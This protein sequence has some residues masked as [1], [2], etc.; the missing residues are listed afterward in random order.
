MRL[1]KNHPRIKTIRT[2]AATALLALLPAVAGAQKTFIPETVPTE[3]PD[4][5]V[6]RRSFK[7]ADGFEVNLW[8][9]D[10]MIAKPIQI[11]WDAQGRMWVASSAMY[12]QI[13]PGE[14]PSDQV[15]VLEDTDDDGKADKST[16]FAD[17]LLI[18]TGVEPGD[19]G[20]YVANSTELIHLKD[21]DGDLKADERRIMLTGF[22]TEDTHHIIHT[23]RWGLDGRMY[24][25]Q[26]IYIHSHVETPHG[27]KRLMGSGIW[28][29]RP[30]TVEFDVFGRGMVNPWGHAFDRWGQSF[31]T[32]GAGGDGIYYAFPGAA[33]QTAK[34]WTGTQDMERVLTGMN[35][36]SPKYCGLEIVSGRHL[37]DDWQY[38]A[39]TNDFRANRV[40]RYQ[41]VDENGTFVSKQMPD[42]ITS[43]DVAFRPIDVKMG[44]DGAIYIADWYNPIINHGEVDFRDPRRDKAHGR[45]WRVSA[46]GRATL[47]KPK[48]V[49]APVADVLEQLKSPEGWT[50]HQ[51][52]LVLRSLGAKEVV[53]ALGAWLKKLDRKDANY[54]H[55][56]VEAL[57]AYQTLDTPEPELLNALL[58]SKTPQAR[59][60]ATR[61][62]PDWA[63][64]LPNPLELLAVQAV[65]ENTRVRIEA[66]RSL[67]RIPL[68]QAF[69]I[70]MTALDNRPEGPIDPHLEYALWTT[71]NEMKSVWMPAFQSGR[72]R[73]NE[74]PEHLAYALQA[75]KSPEALGAL[76]RQLRAGQIPPAARADVFELIASVG[77]PGEAGAV[78]EIATA[79]NADPATTASAL[80]ALDRGIRMRNVQPAD[81]DAGRL[82]RLVTSADENVR[83]AAMRLAGAWRAADVRG[84]LMK[85]AEASDTPPV[86]R[87]SAIGALADWGPES[88]G[89]LRKLDAE[90]RPFAVRAMA[91][92]GLAQLDL[93]DAASRGAELLA[94]APADADPAVLMAAFLQREGGGEALG[95]ALKDKKVN[96]DVAKL[97]LR[98]VNATGRDNPALTQPL[99]EAAG[100]GTGTAVMTPDQLAATMREVQEK[101]DAARGELVFRRS[102]TSCFQCHGIGGAGGQLAPD[103]RAIGA[104]SPLDYLIESI[105]D[106][107]KAIKDGYQSVV[108]A[109]KKG[110]VFSGIKV[111]EDDKQVI[112]R[113]A[114]NDR[115]VIARD[116][117]RRE[118]AGGSLMPVGLHDTLTRGEFLDLVRFMSELGK[119]GKY[120]PDPA[121]LVRRWR[122]LDPKATERLAAD[123]AALL[124][125]EASR[126]LPW[127]PAYSMVSGVLPAD[128]LAAKGQIV[129]FAQAGL[130]VT[131]PGVIGLH[132]GDPA[133]VSL[134]VNGKPVEVTRDVVEVEL[135]RGV[136]TLTFKLDLAQRGADQGLRLEVRDV[137]GS[138]G[139][140]QPLA[141]R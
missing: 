100:L 99:R 132:V 87:Q 65:D 68:P 89:F 101:G 47:P 90:D 61:V 125:P 137:P 22:G 129:A 29:Y 49:G 32:D 26:S 73:F 134:W 60:A 62:V 45:I 130:D 66:V 30:E 88:A 113:D 111:A 94:T 31:A 25:N 24:I 104:S 35:P 63:S 115:I 127:V 33:Y 72:L 118:R 12:P 34:S 38:N 55:Q 8:A 117:V 85:A 106:P 21:T 84:E 141:G 133:G 95:A 57:W 58:R 105:T 135:P 81:A 70:A 19:G 75:V 20:A 16:V 46:K 74:N 40:V 116:S 11:N 114:L 123:P 39:V 92:V 110:E 18:P 52:K 37:P 7:V 109:T 122:V 121:P 140:A 96:A 53:P 27:V 56:R 43:T 48:L 14:A 107:N 91:V 59:A 28:R 1:S 6:E 138:A 126:A 124:S 50:R 69:E 54:E 5:E 120:G 108:I 51:A 4:P 93:D 10:P 102:D 17:G 98:Y 23:F 15:V 64:R 139:H 82:G 79:D 2:A 112:L 44:P 42:V 36:G 119:P 71:A 80:S 76:V 13:K 103:L 128:A 9:A 78:F 131:A 83:A 86:V 67:A 77:G 41:L 136:H 3:P 97:G